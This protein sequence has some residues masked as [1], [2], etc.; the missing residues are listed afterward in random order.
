MGGG[1]I[2]TATGGDGAKTARGR[3]GAGT[4]A[5]WQRMEAAT[6]SGMA[7]S[8]VRGGAGARRLADAEAMRW[9]LWRMGEGSGSKGC[10]D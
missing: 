7:M 6:G 2:E 5:A 9:W 10:G 1:G 3:G 4:A 8:E